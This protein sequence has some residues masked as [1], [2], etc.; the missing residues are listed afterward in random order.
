VQIAHL[1]GSGGFDAATDAALGVFTDAIASHDAR[2]K[3]VWFDATVMVRPGMP[4]DQL[5]RIA[6]RIRQIGVEHV[7]YG[8][9][10]PASPLVYPAAGWAAFQ[11]LPLTKDELRIIADNVTP[12]MRD[13]AVR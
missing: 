9:D 13:L 12:Y 6:A 1:A 7:L 3:N 2:M 10:A 8:S 4:P 11:R 5:Q